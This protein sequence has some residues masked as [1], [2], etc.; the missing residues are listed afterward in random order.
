MNFGMRHWMLC[1]KSMMKSSGK[2]FAV[3]LGFG[4]VVSIIQLLSNGFDEDGIFAMLSLMAIIAVVVVIFIAMIATIY[5]NS[6]AKMYKVC[7]DFGFCPQ[8]RQAYEQ[9]KIAGREPSL[10]ESIGYV[11]VLAKSGF[12]QEALSYAYNL[13]IPEDRPDLMCIYINVFTD[14]AVRAGQPQLAERLVYERNAFIS[15]MTSGGSDT[16][17][18]IIGMA[19][20][21]MHASLGR[22]NEALQFAKLS[23]ECKGMPKEDVMDVKIMQLYLLN[24]LGMTT[25][26]A[27]VSQEIAA[28]LGSVKPLFD[29]QKPKLIEEYNS[30]LNG[31][32]PL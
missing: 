25:E 28:E 20:C 14:A 8:Y 29:W 4:L 2:I 11:E 32:M 5:Y 30:A 19:M 15:S 6:E 31:V 9:Q 23:L 24:V 3:A 26:A 21:L 22:A 7:N 10:M 16:C 27:K 1:F 18:F 12:P 13:W 17:R